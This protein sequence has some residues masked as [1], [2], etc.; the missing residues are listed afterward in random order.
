MI[1]LFQDE[2]IEFSCYDK[3][4]DVIPEPKS[5][6]K[7][8]PEWF[9]KIK[10]MMGKEKGGFPRPTVKKCMPVLDVMNLGYIIPLQADLHVITNH[11]LSIIKTSAREGSPINPAQRHDSVQVHSTSWPVHKQD[12]IKFINNWMIKTKPGWSCLFTAPMNHLGAPFT[13]LSGVV[14]T[15]T[16]NKEINFPAIWHVPNFDDT[17]LAGTPLV[18]VVPFKR[19]NLPAVKTRAVTKKEEKKLAKLGAAQQARISVY[20][21]ELREKR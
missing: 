1:K 4:L 7:C 5:A 9:K 13:C 20:S 8:I 15:D 10:P 14:D 19:E 18:Q 3:W 12:P 6:G 16:Y 21:K 11:D 2:I 17:L